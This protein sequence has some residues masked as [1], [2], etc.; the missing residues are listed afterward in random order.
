MPNELG[1]KPAAAPFAVVGCMPSLAKLVDSRPFLNEFSYGYVA[2]PGKIAAVSLDTVQFVKGFSR[3][4]GRTAVRTAHN[5]DILD[6]QQVGA[7][8]VASGQMSDLGSTTAA[9]RSSRSGASPLSCHS[10]YT[11][12]IYRLPTSPNFATT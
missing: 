3:E 11:V 4:V 2:A 7:L 9:V 10:S 12:K 8:T 6:D 1:H 5:G